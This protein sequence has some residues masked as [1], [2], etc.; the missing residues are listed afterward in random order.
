[1]STSE[2][3]QR[4]NLAKVSR[5]TVLARKDFNLVTQNYSNCKKSDIG[6]VINVD[7]A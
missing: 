5:Y 1:M 4:F 3:R 7:K 2:N 6:T